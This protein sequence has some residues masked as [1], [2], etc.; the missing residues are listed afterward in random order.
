MEIYPPDRAVEFL[1]DSEGGDPLA[2]VQGLAAVAIEIPRHPIDPIVP[3]LLA[4]LPYVAIGVATAAPLPAPPRGFD[5][6]LTDSPKAPRPWVACPDDLDSALSNLEGTVRSFPL[7]SL[8]LVQVLRAGR[9]L[10][11]PS[12]L[13]LESFAFSTLLAGPEFHNWLSGRRLPPRTVSEPTSPV[14]LR[15]IGDTLEITL[16]RPHVHNA[17]NASMRDGLVEALEVV[18]NDPS[19]EAVHLRGAGPS[20]S[21]GGDLREFGTAPDPSTAHL[22][23]T[24]RSQVLALD[25]CLQPVTAF[26]H[27]ACIGAGLEL[28]ARADRIV[29]HP[30]TSFALPE[31]G[32]GLL[33]GAGGTTT[34]PRRIGSERTAYLALSRTDVLV[35]T[36]Q[37]WGLIDEISPHP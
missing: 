21:S 20:F 4:R 19:I 23:R 22:I 27:G 5:V 18:H 28:A 25:R 17:F 14:E 2:A 6:L 8:S 9:P 16:C 11:L 15:R 35:D 36:A 31:I 3:E 13:A 30:G 32:M 37:D 24:I 33:P 10:E 26:V 12:A 1:R 34:I 7:A 29:A